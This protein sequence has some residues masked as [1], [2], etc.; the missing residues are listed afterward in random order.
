MWEFVRKN[1]FGRW[2]SPRT[3]RFGSRT[4]CSSSSSWRLKPAL[5][6]AAGVFLLG[7]TIFTFYMLIASMRVSGAV[8]AVFFV[9]TITFVLLTIGAFNSN[10]TITHIGGWPA[11]SPRR[12]R[13]THLQQGHQRDLQ[14][15][16]RPGVPA[17][18][19]VISG[20]RQYQE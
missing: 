1:T 14:E 6:P 15:G 5:V 9:L 19:Q 17:G 13:G 7:W 18:A 8:V 4:T 16:A 11:S 3:G 10:S 20:Q 2:P 12:W